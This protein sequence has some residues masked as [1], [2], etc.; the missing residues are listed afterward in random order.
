MTDTASPRILSADGFF[1]CGDCGH[2]LG[3][4]GESWKRAVPMR[5]VPL[6]EVGHVFDTRSGGNVR[7]RHFYCPHCAGL[8]DTETALEGDGF[9]EDRLENAADGAAR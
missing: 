7:L 9:L 6:A 5:E 4:T 3:P 8:L 2:E 1:T